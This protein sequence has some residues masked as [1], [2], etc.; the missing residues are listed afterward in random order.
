MASPWLIVNNV[1]PAG[2]RV[3][4]AAGIRIRLQFQE[5][6]ALQSDPTVSRA[7]IDF[8]QAYLRSCK[9]RELEEIRRRDSER[10]L[11]MLQDIVAS[12]MR[13]LRDLPSI[14]FTEGRWEGGEFTA[15]IGTFNIPTSGEKRIVRA[16]GAIL[17]FEVTGFDRGRLKLRSVGLRNQP[18]PREGSLQVDTLAQRRALERQDDAVRAIRADMA[19][20]PALKRII[21]DPSTADTPEMS[22]R[23][24]PQGLSPDK[25]RVLDCA[26]GLRQVMVVQG[27]P[28][29]GKTRLITEVVKQYIHENPGARVLLAAQTHIAID[30]V[31]EKLLET[32]SEDGSIVRIARADEEKVSEK[33]RRALLQHCL[34]RWC[35]ATADK[36]RAFMAQRGAQLGLVADE[37]ELSVR[38]ESLVLAC[39]SVRRVDE[40]L[41]KVPNAIDDLMP[42][43][44]V[45]T[46]KDLVAIESA[47][48]AALTMEQLQA[49]KLRLGQDVQRLRD[50]LRQ[51]STDGAGLADL[52][53][54][55]LREWMDA[56]RSDDKNWLLFRRESEI[57]VA[58]LDLLGQLK[59]FE[60]IVLR[61]AS[62]VAGTCVG[63]GSSEAFTRTEF[64]LCVIDEASKA[65]ATEA[66]IPMVRSRKFLVV[67][68]P[69][70]LP[71][72]D[73]GGY[74][75]DGYAD[76]EIKETLL[77]YLIPKLPK[78][79][80]HEL[81]HQH[82]MCKSIGELISHAF[83]DQRLVNQRL[84]SDR[85]SWLKN[86]YPKPVIWIDTQGARNAAQGHSFI[87]KKEQ[88]LVI[89]LLERLQ[90]D[91]SKARAHTSV[92]IIAGYAAQAHGIDG[93]IQRG[94]FPS[95]AIEVNTVDSFQGRE[96]DVCIFSVTLSNSQDYLGFLRSMERLNVA[97]SRPKDLLVIIGDQNFCYN[98]EGKNPFVS[99]ID[100]IEAHPENC[101]TKHESN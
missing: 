85:P 86:K 53:N 52:D 49:E 95:L 93:K 39:D 63:L 72:F 94:S 58:W 31:I 44:Q 2:N 28:G 35:R 80:V 88:D 84:D 6:T 21:L 30:H 87:N 33:V 83:Y 97:L 79:C 55:E 90:K 67:G 56:F 38:L 26:L 69:R 74:E 70:Q 4:Q 25:V 8:L 71:P 5:R 34:A 19:V 81:T 22:G 18:P 9:E 98:I 59:Q 23:P 48:L 60:E 100:Y 57:Q 89:Q 45:P 41:S 15:E 11:A 42:H 76:E 3:L 101:E 27:P 36:A 62:V 47:T 37:V 68:D 99:V 61:S 64:D 51:L 50:E 66:L 13:A 78:E 7:N 14:E 20:L 43:D 82:R 96:S 65:T 75:V 16:G 29:T 73:P 1:V 32:S 17:V 24:P 54:A 12:R 92:A 46:Q 77:D 10:Y 40:S 91:S